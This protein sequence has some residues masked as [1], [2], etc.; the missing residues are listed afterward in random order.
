MLPIT[1]SCV[2]APEGGIRGKPAPDQLL[3]AM[4]QSGVDPSE[5]L[6]VGDMSADHEAAVRARIDYAHAMWGYGPPPDDGSWILTKVS[7]S[8]ELTRGVSR[9]GQGAS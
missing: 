7:D 1:F 8:L 6:Y 2:H 5:T 9:M 3:I 4:G